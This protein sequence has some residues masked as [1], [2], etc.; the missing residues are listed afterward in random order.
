MVN[1]YFPVLKAN[2]EETSPGLCAEYEVFFLQPICR[3]TLNE[4]HHAK[5]CLRGFLTR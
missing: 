4:P 2:L 3:C 1:S 5:M